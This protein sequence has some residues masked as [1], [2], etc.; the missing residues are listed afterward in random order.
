MRTFTQPQDRLVKLRIDVD[1]AKEEAARVEAE[2][3][4]SLAFAC[5]K[6]NSLLPHG[7]C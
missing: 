3:E 6:P 4:F 1:L 2:S 7:V 5:F